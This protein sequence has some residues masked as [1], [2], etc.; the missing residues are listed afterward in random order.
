[1]RY[2]PLL[3][4]SICIL[5][6]CVGNLA[7]RSAAA[8]SGIDIDVYPVITTLQIRIEKGRINAAYDE[9]VAYISRRHTGV[10]NSE[11]RIYFSTSDAEKLQH[12]VATYLGS[13]GFNM[14]NLTLDST[15]HKGNSRFD[16][17]F[18]VLEYRV[19]VPVCD[20]PSAYYSYQET[21]CAIEAN[22][23]QSKVNPEKSLREKEQ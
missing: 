7:D 21:G 16:F 5:T 3:L 12:K 11:V 23:W 1:M 20:K 18:E 9:V 17:V 19:Q 2:L 14:Q 4:I 13:Q 15:A 22:L 6:G 10:F 8:D